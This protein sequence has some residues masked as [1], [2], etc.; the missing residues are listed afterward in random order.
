MPTRKA[1]AGA[2]HNPDAGNST[3]TSRRQELLRRPEG[4]PGP[5]P[6]TE[7]IVSS[8]RMRNVTMTDPPMI[9]RR[10]SLRVGDETFSI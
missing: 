8:T 4:G 3:F 1:Q 10:G 2:D 6:A 9:A 7:T 5:V